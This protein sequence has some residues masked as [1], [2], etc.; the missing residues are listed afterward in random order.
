MSVHH[1]SRR[2][3]RVVF[4]IATGKETS[5]PLALFVPC[6]N[7]NHSVGFNRD[8]S[9]LNSSQTSESALEMFQFVGRLVG[10]GHRH[11]LAPALSLPSL[12]WK[13]LVGEALSVSDL[14]AVDQSAG[15]EISRCLGGDTPHDDIAEVIT[16]LSPGARDIEEVLRNI[17][18]AH[19]PQLKALFHGLGVALPTELFPL[20]VSSPARTSDEGIRMSSSNHPPIE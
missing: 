11:G 9:V 18:T 1:A 20:C 10:L 6:P 7:A 3:Y 5:G 19:A 2:P 15:G 17:L 16:L 4:E 13:P 12:V 14:I 8:S